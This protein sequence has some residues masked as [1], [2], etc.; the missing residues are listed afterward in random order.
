MLAFETPLPKRHHVLHAGS[1]LR[2]KL[3]FDDLSPVPML[4]TSPTAS[5]AWATP[6]VSS[7]PPLV[8]ERGQV[9][10]NL[11]SQ[12]DDVS[13]DSS[14]DSDPETTTAT[15]SNASSYSLDT[16]A[17]IEDV[18][19]S[20]TK[21]P[22]KTVRR[23][24]HRSSRCPPTPMRTPPWAKKA[25]TPVKGG[26]LRQSSLACTKVLVALPGAPV[27]SYFES[28]ESAKWIGAG[29]FSDVYKVTTSDHEIFAVK[30]S[31]LPLRSKRDR[32]RLL[33]EIKIY[34]RLTH[35]APACPYLVQYFQAW[36][37]RGHLYLQTELCPAGT[38]QDWL[39]TARENGAKPVPEELLWSILHDVSMGLACI[40]SHNIVH[41]D[42]KP[43]N[44]FV[45]ATG[46]VKIGDFGLAMDVAGDG[47][48]EGD[49]TYMA[50]ELLASSTRSAP[51]D[52]FSL[53]LTLLEMAQMTPLPQNGPEWHAL[54]ENNLPK[55]PYSTA[56]TMLLAQMLR[57]E[58]SQRP[59]AA[60]ISERPELV[61]VPST[62]IK[63]VRLA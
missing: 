41:L 30:K 29:A 27:K 2:S 46:M 39:D 4:P 18:L 45:A 61:A 12:F 23:A 52:I 53:G 50:P 3:C 48:G 60:Q 7:P 37:E 15:I 63:V 1:P 32:E 13:S 14:S 59:T 31:K 49:Q 33:Q 42:I 54:R 24:F 28:F 8:Q 11:S 35:S 57:P 5:P 10:L 40:H 17:L 62:L 47:D 36:Q 34:E 38:L 43:A 19:K 55:L 9:R 25:L 16:S 6:S 51:A 21:K 26:L 58:P 22:R 44:L 20:P 56:L